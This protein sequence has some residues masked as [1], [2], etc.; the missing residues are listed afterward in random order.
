MHRN[1]D[2]LPVDLSVAVMTSPIP[3]TSPFLPPL[4]DF[5]PYLESIWK[6]RR[7]T[8]GGDFH[9]Q[10]ERELA[11]YL[12]VKHVSLF[13]NG[14]LA[15]FTALQALDITGDVITTPYSFVATSHALLWHNLNPVFVDVAPGSFNLDPA[16]I[17]AAI[18]PRTTAIMPVHCYGFPCD[19]AGIQALAHAHG[20]K[21]IYDAAHAFGVRQEGVSVLNQ[22]DLA[23]LSFHATK[24]F[25]TF[26]GGA[27]ISHD[28]ATKQRIDQ[29]KNFGF[30]NETTVVGPGINAKMNEVSAAFGLL[31]LRHLDEAL[32]G[33]KRVHDHYQQR[34]ANVPGLVL[35]QTPAGVAWT[36][37]YF[38]V[39]IEPAYGESRDDLHA[40]L[41]R[42]Q[43][44][45]RRYFYPLIT[46]FPMYRDLPSANPA[47][48]PQATTLAEQVICLPIYPHM[49][50]E[51]QARVIDLLVHHTH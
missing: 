26:E 1:R 41:H 50:D 35:P 18:T 22:G 20:L 36:Y 31:Q 11:E 27:I 9:Q 38:P 23:V 44:L 7:L 16:R 28:A 32:V 34:L 40:R 43:V 13:S 48:L 10:L 25:N 15:L 8:N 46:A 12:G 2:F 4:D 33:R 42:H 51:E 14:T 49:T 37:P 45:A 29:L 24:V 6:S 3:V 30:V 47:R 39:L 5:I 17:E 21:V 19:T